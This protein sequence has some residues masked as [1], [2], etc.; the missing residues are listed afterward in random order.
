MRDA[1]CGNTVSFCA[2]SAFC[3]CATSRR[4]RA[5]KAA[6]SGK[7]SLK[8][9]PESSRDLDALREPTGSQSRFVPFAFRICTVIHSNSSKILPHAGR[10]WPNVLR[11]STPSVDF[12]ASK[13]TAANIPPHIWERACSPCFQGP[14]PYTYPW[15]ELWSMGCKP[16]ILFRKVQTM[17]FS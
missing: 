6:S 3:G 15:Y 13:P 17:P 10:R 9:N 11:E 14:C 12:L 16:Q 1:A 2:K 5:E 4:K 7:R 8:Q